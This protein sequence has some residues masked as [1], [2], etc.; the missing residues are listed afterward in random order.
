MKYSKV[1]IV[2]VAVLL[3]GGGSFAQEAKVFVSSNVEGDGVVS[4]IGVI[5]LVS[6]TSQLL[7]EEYPY[8]SFEDVVIGPGPA[9][10]AGSDPAQYVYACDPSSGLIIRFD[11]AWAS[12]GPLDLDGVEVVYQA[13]PAGLDPQC[14]W[15]THNGDFIFSDTNGLG[16]WICYGIGFEQDPVAAGTFADPLC[17]FA[18]PS[19][20]NLAP[21]GDADF[22]GQG[23]TQAADGDALVVTRDT[24][25]HIL[26]FEMDGPTGTFPADEPTPL[27]LFDNEDEELALLD[28]L[29][30]AR[31]SNGDIFVT[32]DVVPIFDG[33][34]EQILTGGYAVNRFV[35]EA[36]E[37]GA[38]QWVLE[39]QIFLNDDDDCG[40]ADAFF[41]EAVADDT[42]YVAGTYDDSNCPGGSL[43]KIPADGDYCSAEKVFG[44]DPGPIFYDGPGDD[45]ILDW[46]PQ[47]IMGLAVTP[48]GTAP[49][50]IDPGPPSDGSQDYFFNFSDHVLELTTPEECTVDLVEARET[51]KICLDAIIADSIDYDGDARRNSSALPRGQGLRPD[52]LHRG[53]LRRARGRHLQVCGVGLHRG[54]LQPT[55]HPV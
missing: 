44:F 5:D 46:I 32:G 3:V 21:L 50:D 10:E 16:A 39:C 8:N 20:D 36:L 27:E 45:V 34:D 24:M 37:S 29:G 38:K 53:G 7:F 47:S 28:S 2:S 41:L 13:G 22:S 31:L 25:G 40:T 14:G 19:V 42:I 11:P 35:A 52:V 6:G 55:D 49:M 15:F 18:G 54:P 30:I 43:W 9:T 51:P 33:N 17:Q 4:Q 26:R 48:T 1:L 23:I 12:E